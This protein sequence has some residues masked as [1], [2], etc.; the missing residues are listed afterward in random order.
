MFTCCITCLKSYIQAR[1]CALYSSVSLI[2]SLM[3]YLS[4]VM[5]VWLYSYLL[6]TI[7]GSVSDRVYLSFG[8]T[9]VLGSLSRNWN[10]LNVLSYLFLCISRTHLVSL[11]N[12]HRQTS[13]VEHSLYMCMV[14]VS[15]FN[16]SIKVYI[17]EIPMENRNCFNTIVNFG[18]SLNVS[19]S[20]LSLPRIMLNVSVILFCIGAL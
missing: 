18:L 13:R 10:I 6:Y 12:R 9:V 19:S 7:P 15:S 17:M 3:F 8:P 1:S 16:H 4:C 14:Y 11:I 5:Y 2:F 20:M